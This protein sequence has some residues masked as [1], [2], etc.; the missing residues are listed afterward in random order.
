[1]I[2]FGEVDDPI[3]T[4]GGTRVTAGF[5]DTIGTIASGGTILFGNASFTGLTGDVHIE[6]KRYGLEV[7]S[8]TG[9]ISG[10]CIGGFMNYNMWTT[11]SLELIDGDPGSLSVKDYVCTAGSVEGFSDPCEFTCALGYCKCVFF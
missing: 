11:Y 1:V 2:A 8:I 10:N 9:I 4:I 7:L 5:S 3:V 6:T